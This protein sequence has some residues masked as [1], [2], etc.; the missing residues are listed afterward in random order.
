MEE[1]MQD[2]KNV[3]LALGA[4]L[5]VVTTA[6]ASVYLARQPPAPQPRKT[7]AVERVHNTAVAKCNDGN[8]AGK[9]VG[10][11]GGGVL[12]SL[13]GKGSGKTAATIGGTL[14]GAYLGGEM[15]PLQN[16]TCR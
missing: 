7:V 11:V 8:I 3:S 12:G 16:A 10:G 1:I 5:L 6:G 4:V 15:I 13:A 14:G 9:A 2:Y